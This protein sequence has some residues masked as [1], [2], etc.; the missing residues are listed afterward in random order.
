MKQTDTFIRAYHDFKK[1]VDLTKSGILPELDDLVW[2][3]LMGVPKVPADEDASQDAQI[4]AIEQR[5]AIL[6]AVFV[7][8]NRN[9]SEDFIDRGLLIYDQAGKVAKILLQ[10]AD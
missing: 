8:T 3:M 6:K 1:T 10:E 5:V 4:T 9:Q 7:E 2:C